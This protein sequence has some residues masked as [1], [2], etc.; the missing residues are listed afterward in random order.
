M[1]YYATNNASIK[2]FN[3]SLILTKHL[4]QFIQSFSIPMIKNVGSFLSFVLF[5]VVLR[6]VNRDFLI[7]EST[8]FLDTESFF[9]DLTKVPHKIIPN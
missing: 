9:N 8:A 7:F 3:C 6:K 1:L 4:T 5:Y 2:F